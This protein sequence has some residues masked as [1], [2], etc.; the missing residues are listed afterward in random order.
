MNAMRHPLQLLIALGA[1]ACGGGGGGGA[2]EPSG[3]G[4]GPIEI[5]KLEPVACTSDHCSSESGWVRAFEPAT[6]LRGVDLSGEFAV[7]AGHSAAELELGV[8]NPV[9]GERSVFLA[10][11]DG[12]GELRWSMRL[13]STPRDTVEVRGVAQAGDLA[14]LAG[15][16][17]GHA[18]F[19]SGLLELE[20]RGAFVACF[21]AGSGAPRW[22]RAFPAGSGAVSGLRLAG[23]SLGR[24]HLLLW[25]VTAFGLVEDPACTDASCVV[26]ATFD[27]DG[28]LGAARAW[29]LDQRPPPRSD[30]FELA[31]DPDGRVAIAGHLSA[32]VLFAPFHL[33]PEGEGDG[34]VVL[35]DAEMSPYAAATW[36]SGPYPGK[37][38]L[39]YTPAGEVLVSSTFTETL[40]LEGEQFAAEEGRDLFVV[41]WQTGHRRTR[42]FPLPGLQLGAVVTGSADGL[43][44]LATSGSSAVHGGQLLVVDEEGASWEL[45]SF[46]TGVEPR[47]I[48]AGAAGDL[49]VGG[50]WRGELRANG[51]E[52]FAQ[53]ERSFLLRR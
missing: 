21:D 31:T 50:S 46:G 38:E 40:A 9:A 32:P 14:C 51:F 11:L 3:C 45:S 27:G 37:V 8:P 48:E 16:L 2:E 20:N 44:Y 36:S 49:W 15:E 52:L 5:E 24:L 1:V 29:K 4:V 23:D 30:A 34:L 28:E 7:V 53:D 42:H 35:L 17:Q 18:D 12:E 6:E 43:L 22:S 10:S 39:A 33:A 26:L 41:G 13:G 25:G 19:G 47:W